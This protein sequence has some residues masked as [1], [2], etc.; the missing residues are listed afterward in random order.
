MAYPFSPCSEPFNQP[1]L[2]AKLRRTFEDLPD[3][4]RRGGNTRYAM[5]DVALSAF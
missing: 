1:N 3:T 4:S 2:I 5:E